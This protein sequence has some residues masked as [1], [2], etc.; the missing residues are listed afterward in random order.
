MKVP[1][2]VK[3][4][5]LTLASTAFYTYVGQLV[6]Q[7]EVQPPAETKMS[8]SMTTADLVA[9]GKTL[10]EGKG[11]CMTCHTIGK[12]SGPMRFPDL[13]GIGGRAATQEPGL[14]ALTYLAKSLY[15]PNDFIVPGFSPGMPV[16]NKPPIGLTDDEIRA[17]IAYLESLGGTPAVTMQTSIPFA[18]GGAAPPASEAVAAAPPTAAPEAAAAAPGAVAPAAGGGARPPAALVSQ[19]Q[20]ADCHA[21]GKQ[22]PSLDTLGARGEPTLLAALAAHPPTPARFEQA[23]T[24]AEARALARFLATQGGGGA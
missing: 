9:T 19:Y 11:S 22:K 8:A 10:L 2:V 16:I 24:L 1:I 3:I 12:T 23:I 15:H 17:V 20:C 13:G 6:P 4:G 7:K 5:A 14:D 18:A 21:E